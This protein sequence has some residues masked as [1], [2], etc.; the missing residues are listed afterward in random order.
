MPETPPSSVRISQLQARQSFASF[1]LL[2]TARTLPNRQ[3]GN[4]MALQ[5]Q[6][7]TGQVAGRIWEPERVWSADLSPPSIVWVEGRAD[8][9]REEMQVVIER[10]SAYEPSD[11]ERAL[12]MKTS[13]WSPA[14]L[15]QRLREHVELGVRS[16]VMR[17]LLLAVLD[18]PEVALRFP[19][20]AAATHNHHA[21]R[22]GLVE[23]TLS[24][25]RLG[26]MLVEHYERYYPGL[27]NG[28]LIIA[29]TLLHDLGKIWEL[30]GELAT[31]YST[32]GN[33]VGHIPMGSS[34]IAEVAAQIGDIP[35]ELV[36]ELQHLVLSH[37]GELEYGA[38]KLPSTA[39]AQLLHYIDNIDARMNMFAG[40]LLEPGFIQNNRLAG[41][42]LLHAGELRR[43]WV[44]EPGADALAPSGAARAVD[45]PPPQ[46]PWGP[47]LPDHAILSPLTAPVG[48]AA[49]VAATE[50]APTDG[51]NERPAPAKRARRPEPEPAAPA[52]AEAPASSLSLFDGL[53]PRG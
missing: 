38:A 25:M 1:F 29:G 11:D 42:P 50:P 22:A 14:T 18:H 9:Y 7:Y 28:D 52:S 19:T 37:H 15:M 16:P 13:R 8:T 34:F 36:W 26:S 51:V 47:G 45:G 24:M 20:S 30:E 3:G 43:T 4:Y 23:H 53:N 40:L 48:P 32:V 44:D 21:Y 41:R 12:L 17:R 33:L 27:L 49:A 5:L 35:R 6:D 31:R 46:A 10:I 2:T 39:E